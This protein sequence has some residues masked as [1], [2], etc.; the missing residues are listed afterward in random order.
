MRITI[1]TILY[2]FLRLSLQAQ[3]IKWMT[4]PQLSDSLNI[5]PKPVFI[6]FHTNWCSYCRKMEKDVFT[7]PEV[8]AAL[9]NKF[10]AVK[11]NAESKDS[12]LFEGKLLKNNNPNSK[13]SIHEIVT[14]LAYRKEGYAF[15]ATLILDKD[16]RVMDRK[17][18]YLSSKKLLELLQKL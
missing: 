3:E 6:F 5:R 8:I 10:Y 12:F 13:K 2:L 11:F 15:P 16:F 9:N 4:F 7:N 18:T 1:I 17:F 14:L